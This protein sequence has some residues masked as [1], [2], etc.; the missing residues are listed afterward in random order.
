M[1]SHTSFTKASVTEEDIL[2]RSRNVGR[3]NDLH[4]RIIVARNRVR[5]SLVISSLVFIPVHC[6]AS[7]INC[8]SAFLFP[9]NIQILILCPTWDP[10]DLSFP[11]SVLGTAS[12]LVV[13]WLPGSLSAT[14]GILM[15]GC[16]NS[17]WPTVCVPWVLGALFCPFWGSSCYSCAWTN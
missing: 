15:P 8:A 16:L 13:K 3:E 17:L 5:D 11:M 1:F 2:K 10:T 9:V 7:L 14:C 6:T 4:G 12:V